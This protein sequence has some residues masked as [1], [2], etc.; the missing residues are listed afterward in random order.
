MSEGRVNVAGVEVSTDHYIDG[1]RVASKERFL[2]R[3]PVDGSALAEISAGGAV[4]AALSR[5]GRRWGREAGRRSC[6]ASPKASWAAPPNSRRSRLS[7][8]ARC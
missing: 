5:P 4:E 7:T 2:D 3:S 1:R 8:T 6:A